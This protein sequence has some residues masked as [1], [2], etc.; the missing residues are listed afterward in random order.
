MIC[1][2]QQAG[3]WRPRERQGSAVFA[4]IHIPKAAG[5][6]L[7]GIL[8]HSFCTRH[9]DV[10]CGN[11]IKGRPRLT[12]AALRRIRWIYW[13]LK[14]IQ[15]HGVVPHGDLHAIG[16]VRFYTLLRQPIQRCASEYQYRVVRGDLMMPFE[17]WITT[18]IA[19]NRMTR[20]IAGCEDANAAIEMIKRRVGFVGLVERFDESLLMWR[21]WLDDARVDIRYSSKNVMTDSNIKRQLLDDPA[22]RAKLEEANREDL[23]LYQHVVDNVY[24]GQVQQYGPTLTA[25]L[26][27]FAST[28]SR[29]RIYPRELPSLVL[30]K[31]VY[32]PLALRIAGVHPDGRARR[33][34]A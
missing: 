22:T 8:R 20:M 34:A 17:Q 5:S 1:A 33:R 26:E 32:R 16:G 23:K 15:G 31:A 29:P 2:G 19:R 30:R 28:N 9:C 7:A 10:R 14:S 21:R 12:A 11:G 4:F 18:E 24:P 3:S 25:D 6:T 13:R 27:A